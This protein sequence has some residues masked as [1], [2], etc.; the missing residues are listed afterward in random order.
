MKTTRRPTVLLR[1]GGWAVI[2]TATLLTALF[3]TTASAADISFRS[4]QTLSPNS[5]M[6]VSTGHHLV[7]QADGNLVLYHDTGS[8]RVA[9]WASNTGGRPNSYLVMQDDGNAV[10]YSPTSTG[11]QVVWASNTGGR[12]GSYLVLQDDGNL[13]I[14]QPTSGS[15]QVVWATNTARPS[16]GRSASGCPTGTYAALCA[17]SVA[18]ARTDIAARAIKFALNQVG[19][20]Y[21]RPQNPCSGDGNN[22]G[23][24]PQHGYDCSGLLWRSYKEAGIDIGARSSGTQLTSGGVRQ[25]IPRSSVRPGDIVGTAGPGHVVMVLADGKI[26][27]AP[28]P[29]AFVR[30]AA[31]RSDLPRAVMVNA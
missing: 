30:V 11:R 29:G 8:G 24:G 10:V 20:P 26:V 5:E 17:K 13:V 2:L 14:Y 9:A 7:M 27:E 25:A 23:E 15:R 28:H 6:R 12:P 4:G 1:A 18:E 16:G 22:F 21:C 3:A 19:H 31:S